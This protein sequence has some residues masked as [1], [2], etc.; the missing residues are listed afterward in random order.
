MAPPPLPLSKR[1]DGCR[2]EA[3]L[4][5]SSKGLAEGQGRVTMRGEGSPC[6]NDNDEEV[7]SRMDGH[8]FREKREPTIP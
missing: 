8:V 3:I 7:V 2:A 6:M 4:E 1:K 5:Y